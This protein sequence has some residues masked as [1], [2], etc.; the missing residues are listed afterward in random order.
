MVRETD[1]DLLD[2]LRDLPAN[3]LDML[4]RRNGFDPLQYAYGR[5]G[6]DEMA[7]DL[8]RWLDCEHAV[9]A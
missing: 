4:A 2:Y 5:Y 8:A 1:A 3:E 9:E 7:R 6:R